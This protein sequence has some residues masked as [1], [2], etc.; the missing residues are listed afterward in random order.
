MGKYRTYQLILHIRLIF[1]HNVSKTGDSD[2]FIWIVVC[3]LKPAI[4][5][6]LSKLIF[7]KSACIFKS[8]HAFKLHLFLYGTINLKP[9]IVTYKFSGFAISPFNKK[10]WR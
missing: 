6:I 9:P 1:Y 8:L 10:R 2:T 4:S 3:H 7:Y 5:L